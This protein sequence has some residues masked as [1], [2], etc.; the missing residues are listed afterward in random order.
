MTAEEVHVGATYSSMLALWVVQEITLSPRSARD[1]EL[2]ARVLIKRAD[3]GVTR[4]FGLE[5]FA[6]IAEPLK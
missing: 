6:Q 2:I 3:D 4:L 5:H 1:E